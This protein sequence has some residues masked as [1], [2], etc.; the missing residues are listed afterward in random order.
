MNHGNG[1]AAPRAVVENLSDFA[2]D[3]LTLSELQVKLLAADLN[4]I[5]SG[6]VA[7]LGLMGLAAVLG[8]GAVPVVLM[9]VAWLLVEYDVLSQAWAFLISAGGGLLIALILGLAGWLWLRRQLAVL[10][11][12][13]LELDRNLTW[14][15][16]V[17]KHR[18]RTTRD[19]GV[20]IPHS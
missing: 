18:G 17:L 7:P 6:A 4:D 14:V 5:K 3:V 15:K 12:S 8:L 19:P 9:G 1:R 11:R 2:H 10:E 16:S 20:V 13:R